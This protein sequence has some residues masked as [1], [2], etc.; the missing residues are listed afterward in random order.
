[1]L[2]KE[3]TLFIIIFISIFYFLNKKFLR[4]ILKYK[5]VDKPGKNKIHNTSTPVSGGIILIF[6]IF[7]Y[8]FVFSN[9]FGFES[10][11]NKTILTF[12]FAAFITFFIGL[13]DDILNISSK[14][15]ILIISIINILL[16]QNIEFFQLKILIFDNSFF[17]FR[18]SIISFSIIISIISFLAY[19]YS[20]TIIDGVNGLFG[21]YNVVFLSIILIYFELDI[22]I[23]NFLY[24]LILVNLF[25]TYLNLKGLL[26]YG[27]SGSLTMSSILP[28]LSLYIYNV[29]EN[30]IYIFS[31]ISLI[32]IPTLDM[33]RLFVVRL[34]NKKDPFSKDLNHLHHILLNKYNLI[35]SLII[36]SCLCFV[37]FVVSEY[38]RINEIILIVIQIS[39]FLF[40][41]KDKKNKQI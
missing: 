28:Y 26:F 38:F 20:L 17:N 23:K 8:V 18:I 36:Y 1:M 5:L 9:F 12:V 7:L 3:I 30:D 22:E 19:H 34:M 33:T 31:Y 16:F 6:S 41:I 29:R 27:N 11:I 37:P 39:I 21:I 40:I 10:A 4:I 13:Y 24:F 25:I 32:I 14:K 35:S 2:I 15:K